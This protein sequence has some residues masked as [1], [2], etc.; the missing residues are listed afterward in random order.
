[1]ILK[2]AEK[3]LPV[4]GYENYSHTM[5]LEYHDCKKKTWAIKQSIDYDSNGNGIDSYSRPSLDFRNVVPGSVGEVNLDVICNYASEIGIISS[6]N[7]SPTAK[8]IPYPSNKEP[9]PQT[10]RPQTPKISIYHGTG[11]ALNSKGYVLTNY[12]VI[13]DAKKINVIGVNGDFNLAYPAVIV[14]VNVDNDLAVLRINDER[15]GA[16]AYSF[17]QMPS[18]VGENV[19]TLGYPLTSTMGLEVKLTNGIISS[20]SGFAGNQSLYQISTPTQSGNSGSPL[21]DSK[22]NVIG[23]VS[24]KHTNAENATYAVKSSYI[25]E[26]IRG[27]DIELNTFNTVQNISLSE[28]VKKIKWHVYLVESTIEEKN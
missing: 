25:Y 19:F 3:N 1:M 18:D 26:L 14:T 15:M 17:K 22:G 4:K 27:K 23:I 8:Y 5:F 12:H 21:F 24:A 16:P 7:T 2:R 9:E 28:Q 6:P 20:N 10:I 13:E 11:F